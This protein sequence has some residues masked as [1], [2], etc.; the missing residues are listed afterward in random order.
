MRRAYVQVHRPRVEMQLGY[1]NIVVYPGERETLTR[2][3][4]VPVGNRTNSDRCSFPA[5]LSAIPVRKSVA[6]SSTIGYVAC[7]AASNRIIK[8]ILQFEEILSDI[9]LNKY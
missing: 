1:R 2:D 9:K 4:H 6:S 5:D 8:V 3:T 7:H